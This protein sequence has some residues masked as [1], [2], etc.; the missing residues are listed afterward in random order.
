[1]WLQS[2]YSNAKS[3]FIIIISTYLNPEMIFNKK[4]KSLSAQVFT[5]TNNVNAA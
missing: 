3:F 1:M 4:F 2:F 5:S